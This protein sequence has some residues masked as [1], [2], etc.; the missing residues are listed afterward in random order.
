[1]RPQGRAGGHRSP[2]PEEV[3][4]HRQTEV[5]YCPHRGDAVM[6]AFSFLILSPWS[7]PQSQLVCALLFA[8]G[9]LG[10]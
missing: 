4:I 9:E 6:E 2:T 10:F 3:G 7:F 8:L 5:R 1:M